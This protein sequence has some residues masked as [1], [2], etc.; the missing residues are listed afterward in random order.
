MNRF[1]KVAVVEVWVQVGFEV[2]PKQESSSASSVSSSAALISVFEGVCCGI[3]FGLVI[4]GGAA[5][6]W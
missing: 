5:C 1:T 4:G 2:A 3:G 6:Y